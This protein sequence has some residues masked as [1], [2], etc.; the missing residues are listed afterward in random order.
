MVKRFIYSVH[1]IRRLREAGEVVAT[2]C[3]ET[4]AADALM[5]L[6]MVAP[7][8]GAASPLAV[9]TPCKVPV[10]SSPTPGDAAVASSFYKRDGLRPSLFC[11]FI[12]L[13]YIIILS[14]YFILQSL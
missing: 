1:F 13:I 11:Y 14:Y 7:R 4:V 6:V 3:G 10:F 8:C 2:D 5:F 9:S 12:L